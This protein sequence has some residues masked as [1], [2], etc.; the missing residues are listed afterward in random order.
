MGEV[1]SYDQG[2]DNRGSAVVHCTC[3]CSIVFCAHI[4]HQE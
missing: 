4:G 1:F 3:T 2:Q